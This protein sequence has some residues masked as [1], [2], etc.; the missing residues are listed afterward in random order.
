MRITI[1]LIIENHYCLHIGV[2]DNAGVHIPTHHQDGDL[3]HQANH[4]CL[5]TSFE[6]AVFLPARNF[7]TNIS[8]VFPVHSVIP[9]ERHITSDQ[10]V[11]R[12]NNKRYFSIIFLFKACRKDENGY[13]LHINTRDGVGVQHPDSSSGW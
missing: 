9:T 4:G 1:D 10:N 3:S 2:R 11:Y 12:S 13:Y 7:P 6:V 5:A 8:P